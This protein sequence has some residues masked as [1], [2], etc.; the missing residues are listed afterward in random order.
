MNRT[1]KTI[2]LALTISSLGGCAIRV[3][4]PARE[5]VYDDSASESYGDVHAPSPDY[6]DDYLRFTTTAADD[7]SQRV[8]IRTPR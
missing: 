8:P 3:A 7:P 1:A 6:G 5:V 4:G 2:A